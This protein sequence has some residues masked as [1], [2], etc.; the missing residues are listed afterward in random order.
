MTEAEYQSIKAAAPLEETQYSEHKRGEWIRYH[1]NGGEQ[2]AEGEII[3]V[4]AAGMIGSHHS[5]L[6]YYVSGGD[7]FPDVDVVWQIDVVE[8]AP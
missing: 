3:F 6:V 2:V 1:V 5:P 4:Q 8:H 7:G